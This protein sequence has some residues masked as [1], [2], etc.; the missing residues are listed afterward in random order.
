MTY[1]SLFKTC[2]KENKV[3]FSFRGHPVEVE[4]TCNILTL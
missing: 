1:T 3:A 4:Q 2:L